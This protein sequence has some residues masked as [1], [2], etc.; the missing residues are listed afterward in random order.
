MD[1]RQ[2]PCGK[3]WPWGC[4]WIN[5][6][7]IRILAGFEVDTDVYDRPESRKLWPDFVMAMGMKIK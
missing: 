2:D 1:G 7:K 6:V 5:A 4:D 3:P